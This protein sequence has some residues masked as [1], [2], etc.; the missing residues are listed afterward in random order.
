MIEPVVQRVE[1]DAGWRG[2]PFVVNY[3]LP[4][5]DLAPSSMVEHYCW[6]ESMGLEN[7]RVITPRVLSWSSLFQPSLY[8]A[9]TRQLGTEKAQRLRFK[10]SSPSNFATQRSS[11]LFHLQSTVF[12]AAVTLS[13]AII[14]SRWSQGTIN[15]KLDRLW[16]AAESSQMASRIDCAALR[17]EIIALVE[18][19]PPP[20]E[21]LLAIRRYFIEVISVLAQGEEIEPVIVEQ[22]PRAAELRFGFVGEL[23][24]RIPGLQAV[25]VYGS[26]V[27][28][29]DFA[30]IDALVVVD[31]PESV[32]RILAGS[33]PTWLGKE[34]NLGV[35][36]P[37]ELWNFQTLSGDNLGGYG[38]CIFG[39]ARLPHKSQSTLFARNLSF[40]VLRQRQQLGMLARATKGHES[41]NGD[42]LRSLHHY[43]VKI[44][45]NVAKGTF[46]A[47][48]TR[49]S[50]AQV[51]D[52]LRQTV[53]FDAPRAQRDV[54]D[55]PPQMPLARSAVATGAVL[56][57][58]NS[59][60]G[61]V[62]ECLEIVQ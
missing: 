11:Q 61:I 56:D 23:I 8:D 12:L 1:H 54:L 30:D 18:R 4:E 48:G 7:P 60:Y 36:S 50:K 35:Y 13:A 27:S 32:L 57:A 20:I 55:G 17:L 38:E 31:A 10:C 41:A 51:T 46:G 58:L 5:L 14:Q 24:E 34:L 28:S 42:D 25:I 2:V 21:M 3:L 9:I 6:A 39:S 26:S 37:E 62:T 22:G 44:P 40:G 47:G 33:S 15:S 29:D 45:A 49:L 43:F 59:R 16:Q 19:Q 52:W 53:D